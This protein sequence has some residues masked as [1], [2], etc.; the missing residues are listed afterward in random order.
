MTDEL[1]VRSL[2]KAISWRVTGT[3]D[4]FMISW[5]VTGQPVIALSISAIEVLTKIVL[6]WIH[7]RM[8][9]RIHWGRR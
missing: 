8:W 1:S 4:T 9:N 5:L 3:V 2:V 7:E 6:F